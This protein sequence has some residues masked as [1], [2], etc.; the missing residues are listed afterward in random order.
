MNVGYATTPP[1]SGACDRFVIVAR[2]AGGMAEDLARSDSEEPRSGVT[3]YA[4]TPRFPRQQRLSSPASASRLARSCGLLQFARGVV[5]ADD[6]VVP[7]LATVDDA[8]AIG[9]RIHKQVEV[10]PD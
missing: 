6:S 10:V 9:L 4:M 3:A 7:A 2:L 1:R 8:R 5:E